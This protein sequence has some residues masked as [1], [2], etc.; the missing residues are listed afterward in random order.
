MIDLLEALNDSVRFT[1]YNRYIADLSDVSQAMPRRRGDDEESIAN[2]G[3]LFTK[4]VLVYL[5]QRKTVEQAVLV[6]VFRLPLLVNI[7]L[8]P[9]YEASF[10]RYFIQA[11]NLVAAEP[12]IF[13]NS[14]IA[15][16]PLCISAF[17]IVVT[18]LPTV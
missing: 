13:L 15:R 5:T 4:T 10:L 7:I 2:A 18:D 6:S 1:E 8:A 14:G 16:A 3:R 9:N 12:T 17:I 11:R